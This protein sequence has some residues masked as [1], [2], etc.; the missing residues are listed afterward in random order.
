MMLLRQR[1]YRQADKELERYLCRRK[2]GVTADKAMRARRALAAA[3][4]DA[5]SIGHSGNRLPMKD[6]IGDGDWPACRRPFHQAM[7]R[8]SPADAM[9]CL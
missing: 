9:D 8:L 4:R 5:Y 6:P 1:R 2:D 7:D 3:S